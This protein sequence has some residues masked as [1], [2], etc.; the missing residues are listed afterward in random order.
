MVIPLTLLTNDAAQARQRLLDGTASRGGLILLER[1][2]RLI[3]LTGYQGEK[4]RTRS[5]ETGI[6]KHRVKP[7][8]LRTLE[9]AIKKAEPRDGQ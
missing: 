3:A 1:P 6:D 4:D 5:R 9:A 8:G 2:V 7:V